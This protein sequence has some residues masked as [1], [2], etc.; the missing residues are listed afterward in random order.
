LLWDLCTRLKANP[1]G[2]ILAGTGQERRDW[3]HVSDAAE[4]LIKAFER[5][6]LDRFV[7]NGGTGQAV[8]VREIAECIR[9]AWKV[10]T[11]IVFSSQSRPGDPFYLV[12]DPHLGQSLGFHPTMEWR[13]GVE[14]YVAWFQK[15]FPK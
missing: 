7:V 8:T 1:E 2:I 9:K 10:E 6:S 15:S 12:A 11:S 3:L 5:A 14:E 4:Y 13:S